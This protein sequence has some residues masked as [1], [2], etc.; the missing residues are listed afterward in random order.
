[1]GR[2]E[3]K[4][5]LVTGAASGIGRATAL[6]FATE[7]AAVMCADLDPSGAEETVAR[8]TEHGQQGIAIRFDVT[9]EDEVAT[10]VERTIAE[11]GRID[12]MFNNAG[13]GG[14]RDF[15]QTI[16]VNLKGVY[17][18][19]KHSAPA[20]AAGGGGSIISTSSIAG[21][22]ALTRAE[23][24]VYGESPADDPPDCAYVATKHGV[25][26]LTRQ[27]ALEYG[28]RGVRVNCVN[29]G[30]IETPMTRGL[31]QDKSTVD[32]IASLHPMGRFGRAEEIAAGVLFLA[33]DQANYITGTVIDV[34]GCFTGFRPFKP[35]DL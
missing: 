34:D 15:D 29:P 4:V 27:F 19:L 33:S 21:L 14:G 35:E 13:I 6:L 23:I 11:F 24:A 28:L 22:V 7:G 8:I 5:A 31:R 25:V 2:L 10:A 18:G 30:Y 1:M 3:K 9:Q 12:V 32:Y 17:Y 16:E 26:G 20:I